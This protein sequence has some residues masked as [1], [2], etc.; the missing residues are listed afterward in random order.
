VFG[1]EYGALAGAAGY[2]IMNLAICAYVAYYA[3][4]VFGRVPVDRLLVAQLGAGLLCAFGTAGGLVAAS[5]AVGATPPVVATLAAG[6]AIVG[7]CGPLAALSARIRA[8]F[9]RAAALSTD[10]LRTLG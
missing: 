6:G 2:G 3:R 7:F 1:A 8:V 9:R 4:D 5:Q 10:R